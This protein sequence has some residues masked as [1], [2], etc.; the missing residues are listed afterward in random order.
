M[1][2][3]FAA[4]LVMLALA[5][6]D[7]ALVGFPQV[8][9]NNQVETKATNA[10]A[11]KKEYSEREY[12]SLRRRYKAN[13]PQAYGPLSGSRLQLDARVTRSNI[14]DVRSLSPVV[15]DVIYGNTRDLT[16]RL[17]TGLN[18]D[19]TVFMGYPLNMDVS[20]LDLAI[21]A[22][23]R[24][25][26]RLLLTHNASVNPPDEVAAD[27]TPLGPEAPLPLAASYGEDDVVKLLLHRG[28]HINQVLRFPHNHET[29][30][31]AAVYAQDISTVY[32]LLTHGADIAATFGSGGMVP[33]LL[34]QG[35]ITPPRMVALCNLL[36]EYGAKMPAA[37]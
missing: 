23:Q 25:V 13:Q 28:A 2:K 29:A 30:L 35:P 33:E 26:I 20:L 1:S 14:V 34:R 24:G 4:I 8:S 36:I 16:S 17:V 5:G 22:G 12:I 27:G 31:A 19:S 9:A 6:C 10:M 3:S 18:P 11:A 37:H 7:L 15:R 32:L 21:Q